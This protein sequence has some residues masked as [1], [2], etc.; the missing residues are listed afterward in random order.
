[1]NWG[2]G[3]SL[4]GGCTCSP[5]SHTHSRAGPFAAV[6]H[7]YPDKSSLGAG[8]G[9]SWGLHMPW[10]GGLMHVPHGHTGRKFC[11]CCSHAYPNRLGCITDPSWEQGQLMLAANDSV[12]A[13]L[14]SGT[15][16]QYSISVL[17]SGTLYQ[18]SISLF[19]SVLYTSVYSNTVLYIP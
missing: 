9:A 13:V 18:Y 16:Y 10:C 12:W 17:Y 6:S 19:Y 7:S 2:W 8:N 11:C 3:W 15:L 14:Y 1:M 4:A 5:L